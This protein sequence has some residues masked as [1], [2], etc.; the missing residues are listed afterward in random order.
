MRKYLFP[1]SVRC[2]IYAGISFIIIPKLKRRKLKNNAFNG[3]KYLETPFYGYRKIT[4]WLQN[5][6]FKINKKEQNG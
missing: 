1:N 2:L 3:K 6:G 4:V 5:Q